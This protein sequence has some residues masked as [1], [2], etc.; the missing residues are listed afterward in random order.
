MGE[1]T[2][3]DLLRGDVG[4]G[5]NGAAFVHDGTEFLDE[6]DCGGVGGWVGGW[7]EEEKVA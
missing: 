6:G 5:K 4:K 1:L 7:V 2:R 3:D